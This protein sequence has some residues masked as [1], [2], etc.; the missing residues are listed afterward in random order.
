MMTVV[1][2]GRARIHF[3]ICCLVLAWATQPCFPL[4]AADDHLFADGFDDILFADG[5]ESIDPTF[6]NTQ[7]FTLALPPAP[8]PVSVVL[9]RPKLN[10]VLTATEQQQLV[11]RNVDPAP[12]ISTTLAT[13]V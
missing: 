7:M 5:F 11:L 8:S 9:D 2:A 13:L 3:C 4:E 10:A 6:G 12:A 1:S